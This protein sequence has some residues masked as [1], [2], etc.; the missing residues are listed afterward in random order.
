MDDELR[1]LIVR[2]A[3]QTGHPALAAK[4]A[5]P[6]PRGRAAW[7]SAISGDVS[8]LIGCRGDRRKAVLETFVQADVMEPVEAAF[9]GLPADAC[10]RDLVPHQGCPP[11]AVDDPYSYHSLGM[12]SGEQGA[13]DGAAREAAEDLY[14]QQLEEHEAA[15]AAV[16]QSSM[17]IRGT[18]GDGPWTRVRLV[19]G[20]DGYAPPLRMLQIRV[21]KEEDCEDHRVL[22]E[23]WGAQPLP[24]PPLPPRATLDLWIERSGGDGD[25]LQLS[26]T[27]D[28]EDIVVSGRAPSAPSCRVLCM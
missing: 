14:R 18:F 22:T 13:T 1:A 5:D 26:L 15:V 7:G 9:E 20:T 25:E 8:F 28:Q 12:T 6:P 3:L 17:T 23:V 11:L 24:I 2:L 21:T 27:E 16:D 4:A 19:N 10:V